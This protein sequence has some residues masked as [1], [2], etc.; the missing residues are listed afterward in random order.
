MDWEVNEVG[1]FP[2]TIL[3]TDREGRFSQKKGLSTLGNR[4]L[5]VGCV[6]K[7][8]DVAKLLVSFAD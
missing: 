4:L 8:G 3:G 5:A 2:E 7:R 6:D 1:F